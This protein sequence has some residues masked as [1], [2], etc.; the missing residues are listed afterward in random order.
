MSL[1]TTKEHMWFGFLPFDLRDLMILWFEIVKPI[2]LKIHK[3]AGTKCKT[4]SVPLN[5]HHHDHLNK[6]PTIFFQCFFQIYAT[7]ST[8]SCRFGVIWTWL[9][10]CCSKII[11]RCRLVVIKEKSVRSQW[12]WIRSWKRAA[13]WWFDPSPRVRNVVEHAIITIIHAIISIWIINTH[14][15]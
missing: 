9:V 10:W 13:I 5:P 1:F 7:S 4:K 2:G 3:K 8:C 6:Y 11:L 14:M 15:F 12:G